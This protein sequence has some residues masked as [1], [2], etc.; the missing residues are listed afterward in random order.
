M[1][2][3][4]DGV[5]VN[6]GARTQCALELTCVSPR[7][8]EGLTTT[9]TIQDTH[10]ASTMPSVLSSHE[11]TVVAADSNDTSDSNGSASGC[12]KC[13][14]VSGG[15]T[16]AC[17]RESQHKVPSYKFCYPYACG[18]SRDSYRADAVDLVLLDMGTSLVGPARSPTHMGDEL[19]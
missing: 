5:D 9:Y 17:E 16:L 14:G 15:R 8:I 12:H 2:R 4:A 11:A 19:C 6:A 10:W 13:I 18:E 1:P 7:K 3:D